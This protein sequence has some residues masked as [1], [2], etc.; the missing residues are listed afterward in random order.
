MDSF[1]N[2]VLSLPYVFY[3]QASGPFTFGLLG[4]WRI[5]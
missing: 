4:E 1:M 2:V 3:N 5:P